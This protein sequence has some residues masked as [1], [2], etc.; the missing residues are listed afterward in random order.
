M[1]TELQFPALHINHGA[2][3]QASATLDPGAAAPG[4]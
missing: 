1:I 2:S 4:G 3:S